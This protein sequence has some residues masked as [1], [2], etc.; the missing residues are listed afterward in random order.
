VKFWD[1]ATLVLQFRSAG[2]SNPDFRE[3]LPVSHCFLIPI[4]MALTKPSKEASF[5]KSRFSF[6]PI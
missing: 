2:Q 5:E 6:V 1:G 4:K 3:T